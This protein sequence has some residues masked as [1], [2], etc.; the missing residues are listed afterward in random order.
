L[1]DANLGTALQLAEAAAQALIA[2]G[3]A[4]APQATAGPLRGGSGAAAAA[5]AGAVML[6]DESCVMAPAHQLHYNDAA[7]LASEGVKLAHE[8]LSHAAAEALGVR[9][10]RHMHETSS[11]H[12]VAAD[13]ACPAL[14]AATAAAAEAHA[15]RLPG[16]AAGSGGA[17]GGGGAG[18]TLV[19]L[20]DLMD[21]ADAA[22]C[23]ELVVTLDARQHTGR[24]LLHQG[25]GRCQGAALCA[26]LEGA[27]LSPAELAALVG[28]QP[29][30]SFRLRG[31]PVC[32]G[33]GLAAAFG[34]SDVCCALAGDACCFFDPSG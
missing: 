28:L 12:E 24:A 4:A 31:G 32:V 17:A 14:E 15:A 9:S 27:P 10:L 1:G 13:L 19:F 16:G 20:F 7:W 6:P 29:G 18:A 23:E 21:V 3:A 34:V 33:Q 2:G 26:A 25:L 22:G 5:A 8:G 30:G 11:R